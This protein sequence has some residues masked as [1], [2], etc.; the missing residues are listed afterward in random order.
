MKV[1]LT[2]RSEKKVVEGKWRGWKQKKPFGA[3]ILEV[4]GTDTTTEITG[5]Y[6]RQVWSGTVEN[7]KRLFQKKIG[8]VVRKT[9]MLKNMKELRKLLK[10]KENLRRTNRNYS[11]KCF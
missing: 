10:W 9:Q 5:S 7:I 8:I 4:I 3:D 11:Y 1:W 2:G 6:I